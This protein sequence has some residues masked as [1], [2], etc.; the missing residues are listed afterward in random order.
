MGGGGGGFRSAQIFFL[1]ISLGGVLIFFR[2][3][4]LF[5]WATRCA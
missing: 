1:N 5:F 3:Q 4:E 2:M